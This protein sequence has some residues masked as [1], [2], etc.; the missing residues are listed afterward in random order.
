M[1]D[2]AI[3]PLRRRM[4]EDMTIRKLAASTQHNYIRSV[5]DFSVFFGR[6]PDK[7]SLEDVR[8]FHLHLA[9]NGASVGMM[10]ATMIALRFFFREPS[11]KSQPL[12]IRVSSKALSLFV[13]G[14]DIFDND[15]RMPHL[16]FEAG[17]HCT[18]DSLEVERF[19]I[20]AGAAPVDR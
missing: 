11:F 4:I 5:K 13:V 16:G 18:F 17:D 20:G 10:N 3:S 2:K 19:G 12:G 8:R 6:S 15:L 7:A 14:P 9:S 1:T